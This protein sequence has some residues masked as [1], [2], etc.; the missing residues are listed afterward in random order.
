MLNQLSEKQDNGVAGPQGFDL[1]S[2]RRIGESLIQGF[3]FF[4]GAVSILTTVGIL[5]VLGQET[6]LFF[7]RAEVTLA[8]FF[9]STTWQPAILDFGIWPLVNATLLTS[10]IA[11]L[12]ALPLGLMIALYLS[13]YASHRSRS[14]L[15]PILEV[16]AGVPTVEINPD[17]TEVSQA[18][19]Y[20]L[21]ARAAEALAR[22]WEAAKLGEGPAH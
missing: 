10:A 3:L 13:E 7:R 22:I 19:D 21:K 14:I 17:R 20:R 6:W 9:T 12:V 16:L 18:V 4:C 2:R 1:T 15:K 8:E 11:M 5:Y